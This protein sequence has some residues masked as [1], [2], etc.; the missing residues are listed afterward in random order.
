M[1]GD[2]TAS[3]A[4]AGAE[5]SFAGVAEAGAKSG[6]VFESRVTVASAESDV[7]F[8]GTGDSEGGTDCV[9]GV[10]AETVCVGVEDSFSASCAGAV[11]VGGAEAATG[12]GV[13]SGAACGGGA[14]LG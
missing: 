13:G 5:A 11:T 9:A 10:A 4:E 8:S 2:S 3:G 1:E 12:W 14:G 7:V 6:G